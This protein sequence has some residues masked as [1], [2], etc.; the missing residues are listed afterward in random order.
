MIF[1]P[2]D[3]QRSRHREHACLR[4]RR[5]HDEAGTAVGGGIRGYD[6]Q[7]VSAEL[8]RYPS[9]GECL[10]A[11]KRTVEHD[12]HDGVKGV[13]GEFLCACDKIASGIV[14]DRIDA[15]KLLLGLFRR[16]FYRSVVTHITGGERRRASRAVNLG[17]NFLEWFFTAADEV[18]PSAKLGKAQGHRPAQSGSSTSKED[19]PAF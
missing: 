14:D 15:V 9:L 13:G 11:M 16:G 1:G 18:H 5:R 2:L 19:S 12:A 6:V 10:R 7:D 17:T 8:L 3:C 4:T